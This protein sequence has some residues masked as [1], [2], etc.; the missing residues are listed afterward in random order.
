MFFDGLL[1]TCFFTLAISKRVLWTHR[2]SSSVLFLV[3]FRWSP[4]H[5]LELVAQRQEDADETK[6][7]KGWS[8]EG[9]PV[10]GSS[11]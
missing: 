2:L 4:R 7:R 10:P 6:E 5:P 9:T 3:W 1:P 11:R 8:W